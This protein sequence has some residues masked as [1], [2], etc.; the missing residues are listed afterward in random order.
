MNPIPLL[1]TIAL[2]A[3]LPATAQARP[4][5]TP[6]VATT[7]HVAWIEGARVPYTATVAEQPVSHPVSGEPAAM[8]TTIAYVRNDVADPASRPV[9]FF[10]NGGP[11]ASSSP[12]HMNASGPMVRDRENAADRTRGGLEPNVHSALDEIDLVFID[13]VSTGFSRHFPGVDPKPFYDTVNDARAVAE[14][15]EA[16]LEANG[17]M[18]SPRFLAGESYGTTRA[19][20]ILKHRPDLRWD[21]VLLISGNSGRVGP[22]MDQV[23]RIP[24]MAAAAWYHE[25]IDRAG[26]TAQEVYR[27]AKAFAHGEYLA[28]LEAGEDL[29]P[30]GRR[31]VAEK[32]AALIGLDADAIEAAGLKA[33]EMKFDLALLADQGLR[34]GRLDTRVTAPLPVGGPSST[35]IDD[36][37]LNVVPRGQEATATPASIGPVASPVVG[38]YLRDTLGFPSG[39]EPY[40]GVNFTA[41]SQWSFPQSQRPAEI[42]AEAMRADPGLRLYSVSG[43]YDLG[44]PDG[45]GYL[46]A[47]VP[48]DRLTMVLLPGP[49][50]VYDGPGNRQRFNQSMRDFVKGR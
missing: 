18:D 45:E 43:M 38:N 40:Y 35:N 21:G 6:R 36:P 8:V 19:P 13:P 5:V 31:R 34:I 23:N 14:A 48:E 20:M 29:D 17:R 16:W 39:D 10:F 44:T 25:R 33:T 3:L 24:T 42:M 26:R 4:D 2:A 1:C 32:L 50:Q 30:A 7:E 41:N 49:H 46:Q 37:S 11:G 9:M 47:G 28:A 15:I 22:H 27:E 12:L